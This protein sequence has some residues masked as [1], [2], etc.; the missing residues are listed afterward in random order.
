MM[1]E[2]HDILRAKFQARRAGNRQPFDGVYAK[3]G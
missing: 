3:V 1:G 2:S